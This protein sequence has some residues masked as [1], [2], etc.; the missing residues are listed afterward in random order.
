[1][2]WNLMLDLGGVTARLSG[3]EWQ[4]VKIP[5][6]LTGSVRLVTDFQGARF[7]VENVSGQVT[8]YAPIIEKQLRDEGVIDDLA[9]VI[10]HAAD[11]HG[12]SARVFYSVVSN[13]VIRKYRDWISAYSDFLLL[14]P[15]PSVL[16]RYARN[17]GLRDGALLFLHGNQVAVLAL[18]SG[19]VVAA[20]SLQ[21]GGSQ[22]VECSRIA[23]RIW[24]MCL[25]NPYEAQSGL[26]EF[27]VSHDGG[28][29]ESSITLLCAAIEEAA[30]P[31]SGSGSTV[32][33]R[34][35][36][37]A[38]ILADLPLSIGL[39][40]ALDRGLYFCKRGV[41]WL[42]AILALCL[43]VA[44]AVGGYWYVQRN[45]LRASLAGQ[46]AAV[47][48][49]ISEKLLFAAKEA[50]QLDPQLKRIMNTLDAR[51][52]AKFLPEISTLLSDIRAAAT[53]NVKVFMVGAVSSSEGGLVSIS[54]R[55]RT[56]DSSFESER[57]FIR[58]LENRGYK[59]VK[60][61]VDS[62]ANL[63]STFKL[64]IIRGE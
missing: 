4:S 8:A 6:D 52:R 1:M 10:V 35:D 60:R 17:S 5:D 38:A 41:P 57:S 21:Y 11:R 18:R 49:G 32:V 2:T 29:A 61:E 54:F 53:D 27:V 50:E 3:A 55:G 22:N 30:P 59:V 9:E 51:D 40:P 46:K 14:Y 47:S 33:T 19:Q 24:S 12:G 15:L 20:D 16:L 36:D 34:E 63:G 44:I 23:H 45:D 13:D 31:N 64:S 62:S 39:V 43:L 58:A 7:G 48:S 42:A 25:E 28:V 37:T 56:V 26:L